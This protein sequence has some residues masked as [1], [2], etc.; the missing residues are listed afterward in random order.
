LSSFDV[1]VLY[2]LYWPCGTES[3]K[4]E[5][6][7]R[8]HFQVGL[9]VV[10]DWSVAFFGEMNDPFS[11]LLQKSRILRAMAMRTNPPAMDTFWPKPCPSNLP[12]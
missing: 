2:V 11:G 5:K 9:A 7:D 10:N 1:S 8:P 4:M 6:G 3:W 12:N